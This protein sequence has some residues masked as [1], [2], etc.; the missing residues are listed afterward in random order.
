MDKLIKQKTI[1][2]EDEEENVKRKEKTDENDKKKTERLF[3]NFTK[4]DNNTRKDSVIS[5]VD[6]KAILKK[7]EEK[8]EDVIAD[9]F[10][11]L[12]ET[13]KGS[14]GQIHLTYNRRDDEVVAV[15]K[16]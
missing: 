7:T 16:V 9:N 3:R 6:S 11:V 5:S 1:K 4:I 10:I 12:T 2:N 8:T 13:G 15:K 14:F